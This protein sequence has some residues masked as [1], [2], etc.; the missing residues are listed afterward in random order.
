MRVTAVSHTGKE[1]VGHEHDQ[2]IDAKQTDPRLALYQEMALQ[3]LRESIVIK[4][5]HF[6]CVL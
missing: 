1:Q 4:C 3:C 5:I 2:R 6:A